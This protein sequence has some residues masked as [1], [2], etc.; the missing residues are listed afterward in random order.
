MAKI[1]V[2]DSPQEMVIAFARDFAL[3]S[4]RKL[5]QQSSISVALS[6]GSTPK[7]LFEIWG[8]GP[9]DAHSSDFP[10]MQARQNDLADLIESIPWNKIHLFWGDERCVP[11]DDPESNY[12]VAH[13][14]WLSRIDIP[15]ANV[16]RV[17]GEANPV[18]EAIRYENEI[19]L[20]FES[21]G[22]Q[23]ATSNGGA[24]RM[25]TDNLP[26]AIP[27]FDLIM[28]GMGVDGHTASIFPERLDLFQ[29]SAICSVVRHPVSNQQR[30]TLTGN[31]INQASRIIFLITGADKAE[32][33][34]QVIEHSGNFQE[35]PAAHIRGPQ[36]EFFLDQS[37]AARLEG[38]KSSR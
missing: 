30:I 33:L 14:T 32:V 34:R 24:S 7:R 27:K 6:G 19:A 3:W 18:E 17:R 21:S 11:A 28:L 37:A 9:P 4:R 22:H 26:A 36:V 13:K 35:Y 10:Q 2:F 16:H 25:A 31:V 23:P 1:H 5:Q 38:R 20:Y 29:S 8:G 12:G 15:P